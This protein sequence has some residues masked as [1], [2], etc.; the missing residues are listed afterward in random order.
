MSENK[1]K[2]GFADVI[3]LIAIVLLATIIFFGANFMTLG[4]KMP[5]IV[6]AIIGLILMCL[7]V[8]L[9][10]HAKAQIQEGNVWKIVQIVCIALYVILLIPTYIVGAKF[11]N[12]QF[13]RQGVMNEYR[14]DVNNINGLF[15]EYD[16]ICSSRANAYR[17][18]MQ[19]MMT[20]PEGRAALA[21]ELKIDQASLNQSRVE[22]AASIFLRTLKGNDYEMLVNEKDYLL[23]NSESA[24]KNWNILFI[25]QYAGEVG[26][27]YGIYADRL[28]EIY[29]SNSRESEKNVPAF[30]PQTPDNAGGL[31][32]L[33]T[34]TFSFSLLGLIVVF[35]LG[36]LGLFKY[37][38]GVKSDKVALRRGDASVI[39]AGG[40]Y[41]FNKK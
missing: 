6:G 21:K 30:D 40:G 26:E 36:V 16:R 34:D 1:D 4:D 22:Q 25:P 15:Q 31:M 37:I 23:A 13:D 28:K 20:T 12:I 32:S 17:I 8:F 2:I 5:A 38:F 18:R 29:D 35:F 39:T 7:C 14:T 3:S 11:F 10:A 24:F 9:A 27:S 19:S 33:F 41:R